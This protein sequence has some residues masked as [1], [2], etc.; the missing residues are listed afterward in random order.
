LTVRSS[1][2]GVAALAVALDL[3]F[4]EPPPAVH[5]TVWMGRGLAAGRARRRAQ[6]TPEMLLEGAAVTL[7]VV[8][9]AALGG[10]LVDVTTRE[11]GM[12]RTLGRSVALK[13][14]L[15][16]RGLLAASVAVE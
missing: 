15:A 7:G 9:L 2:R 5:P 8:G 12:A 13:P 10:H 11:G 4:G 1:S 14:T 3:I 6:R 16:L